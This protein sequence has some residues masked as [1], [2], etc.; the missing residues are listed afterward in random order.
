MIQAS[1]GLDT[2]VSSQRKIS[3]VVS[4]MSVV[5]TVLAFLSVILGSEIVRAESPRENVSSA[6]SRSRTEVMKI[7]KEIDRLV[8]QQLAANEQKLNPL[9]ND[10]TFVRRVYLDIVGRIPT[11]EETESFLKNRS[12]N[13]RAELIDDLLDSYGYVSHQ[14]NLWADILRL[15]TRLRNI[16]GDGYIDYVKDSLESNKPYDEFVRELLSSSGAAMAKGNGQVGYYLRD[17]GMPEDN[18]SNTIRI[19]LGTRLECAQCHDHPF[20]KWTQRQYFE[21]VAFTGGMNYQLQGF[22]GIQGK[23]Y[24]AAKAMDKEF[25]PQHRRVAQQVLRPLTTGISGSGTGLA[26][27]PEGFMGDD[28]EE[29]DIIKAKTMFEGKSIVDPEIPSKRRKGKRRRPKRN[30]QQVI[31]G[32]KPIN[33]RE[34][35]AKW[36]T[37]KDNPRFAKVIANRLWKRAFGLGLVEPVDM[38]DDDTKASNPELMDFLAESMVE[39]D[40]DM[41][42]FYRAIYNSRTYQAQAVG[43]DVADPAKFYFNGP[44]VRRMSAEQLWDSLLTLAVNDLDERYRPESPSYKQLM[45]TDDVY[46]AI[47]KLQSMSGREIFNM[48]DRFASKGKNGLKN[49]MMGNQKKKDE[50]KLNNYKAA[51][52]R[53]NRQLKQARRSRDTELVKELMIKK[54]DMTAQYKK[55]RRGGGFRRASELS[56]PAPPGHF[57]REFGQSDRDQIENANTDPAVTQ[58]LSLMNGFIEGN[59]SSNQ[60]TVL[61]TN[62]I[63]PDRTADKVRATYMTMLSRKPSSDEVRAWTSDFERSRFAAVSD[64]IWVIANSNEFIFVK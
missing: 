28:G 25:T 11:L 41:K 49:M 59:I 1:S 37:D 61:V 7:S 26:V 57:L 8:G 2:R 42:Q 33:S 27:L 56:S 12:S 3:A 45:G 13:K 48:I 22:G 19:F 31:P 30:K 35:Y 46:E 62:I 40:F 55:K 24:K 34:V 23:L 43:T 60:S 14:Y 5:Y 9:A 64:L 58:V 6:K 50:R 36:L 32:A 44:L 39:L 18:M 47:E 54:A 16:R 38:F 15:K 17:I 20:D 21:M 51:V 29:G 53:L 52:Q 4:R 63:R 10:S